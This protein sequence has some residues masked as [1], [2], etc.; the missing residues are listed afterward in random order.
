MVVPET[1]TRGAADHV[2]AGLAGAIR[3]R[4]E[5]ADPAEVEQTH[6]TGLRIQPH[7]LRLDVAV[8]EAGL[9]G[10]DQARGDATDKRLV[11]ANEL[12]Q[13]SSSPVQ[14]NRSSSVFDVELS[15]IR[16]SCEKP[17]GK[18]FPLKKCDF[19]LPG[20]CYWTASEVSKPGDLY[21][22]WRHLNL[23]CN[24]SRLHRV[25][26]CA[27]KT[28]TVPIDLVAFNP[29]TLIS[30][31]LSIGSCLFV[32]I[33]PQVRPQTPPSSTRPVLESMNRCA[34]GK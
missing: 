12:S 34:T 28:P 22:S 32:R 15:T 26:A 20:R 17:E 24:N 2:A 14:R 29:T 31:R 21:R 11:K 7:V 16:W 18:G 6:L 3:R 4:L 5:F 1:R 9:M 19:G 27:L 10:V 23:A 13:S 25:L 8:Q 30:P 33:S